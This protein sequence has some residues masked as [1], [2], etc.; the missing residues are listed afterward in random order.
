VPLRVISMRRG[1]ARSATGRIYE[2][3]LVVAELIVDG[4]DLTGIARL[5]DLEHANTELAGDNDRLVEAQSPA[6][7]R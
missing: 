5:L 7:E 3:T 2:Y 1:F 4:I 6:R